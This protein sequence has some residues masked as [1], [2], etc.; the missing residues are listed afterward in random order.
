MRNKALL[1][2][3]LLIY[4]RKQFSLLINGFNERN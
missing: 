4:T 2:Y 1:I 3:T